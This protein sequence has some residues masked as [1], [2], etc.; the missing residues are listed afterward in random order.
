MDKE[1]SVMIGIRVSDSVNKALTDKANKKGLTVSALVKSVVEEFTKGDL[2]TKY[3]DDVAGN[4]TTITKDRAAPPIAPI[5]NSNKHKAGDVVSIKQGKG[6]VEMTVPN[7]DADG[8]NIPWE[9]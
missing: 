6:Y 1:P 2:L 5:Y 8:N 7:L 4:P 9:D 3:K